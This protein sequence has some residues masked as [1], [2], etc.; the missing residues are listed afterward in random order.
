MT[1]QTPEDGFWLMVMDYQT[2]ISA[3]LAAAI[4]GI[5][6]LALRRQIRLMSLQANSG[7][8][9]HYMTLIGGLNEEIVRMMS[10]VSDFRKTT[11][12]EIG[13]VDQASSELTSSHA[14]ELMQKTREMYRQ[15]D[16]SPP[17]SD[18]K[19]T[20]SRNE[21]LSLL[22][23]MD[24]ALDAIFRLGHMHS[25]P[26]FYSQ[27]QCDEIEENERIFSSEIFNITRSVRTSLTSLLSSYEDSAKHASYSLGLLTDSIHKNISREINKDS[28]P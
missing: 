13:R 11:L 26:D 22:T 7:T 2:L 8:A 3:I 20:S 16:I 18:G 15:I 25:Y 19:L 23:E 14:G 17:V 4:A 9:V 10:L 24:F 6:F 12:D 28:L 1:Y 27:E 5:T 21:T